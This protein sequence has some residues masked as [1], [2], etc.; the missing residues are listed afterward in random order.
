MKPVKT[1]PRFQCDFC[2]RRSVRHVIEKHEPRCFRN[3]NRFC[4]ECQNTREVTIYVD[5]IAEGIGGSFQS[6]CQYCSKFDAKQLAEIEERERLEQVPF[7]AAMNATI[8]F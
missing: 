1:Q 4:D 8:P 5:D 2:K 7:A 3:P 6:P